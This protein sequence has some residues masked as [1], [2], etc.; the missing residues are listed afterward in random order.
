MSQQTSTNLTVLEPS[1]D[2]I[3]SEP[4]SIENY[5]DSFMDEIFA[6]IDHILDSRGNLPSPILQPST[7]SRITTLQQTIHTYQET[8]TPDWAVKLA[9][10]LGYR[11]E[12]FYKSDSTA[13][14]SEYTSVEAITMPQIVLPQIQTVPQV[15]RKRLSTVLV[16]NRDVSKV[17][18]PHRKAWGILGKLVFLG[19]PLG[20]VITGSIWLLHSGILNRLISKFSQ[21]AIL[22]SQSQ[23]HSLS[24]E[25]V[26]ADFADYIT[27][28]LAAIERQEANNQKPTKTLLASLDSPNQTAFT[29]LSDRSAGN[30]PKPL[31]ANNTPP[32]SSVVERVYIP[33]YQAPSPMRYAPP[34]MLE[35]LKPLPQPVSLSPTQITQNILPAPVK[36][37]LKALP[38][39]AKSVSVGS[40]A[41]IKPVA[42]RTSPITVK[43]PPS[44]LPVTPSQATRAKLPTSTNSELSSAKQQVVAV[45]SNPV[46]SYMLEGLLEL[47]HKSAALFKIDGITH[48]VEVGES[49][50]SSGWTLVEVAKGEAII[51]R[52]GEVRSVYTGQ[53]F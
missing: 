4:W 47:G 39:L 16:D 37:A 49:I 2:L 35:A 14:P 15:K 42:V 13:T 5:A 36:T 41:N 12:D 31:A 53:K 22:N 3:A 45:V 8:S 32:T 24:N 51:R 26:E 34:P 33:V 50:G 38:K 52:N 46:P 20:L 1:E 44:P 19:V 10:S 7:H 23:A 27:E 30:L 43:Q 21:Q 18:K 40:L 11:P 25:K 9:N 29:Y 28:S 17:R 6:D 48:R